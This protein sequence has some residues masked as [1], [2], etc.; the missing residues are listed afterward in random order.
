MESK[1]NAAASSRIDEEDIRLTT[2]FADIFTAILLVVGGSLLAGLAGPLGGIAI[3]GA[4]FL[5]GKPLVERRRFAASGNALAIGA[6]LGAAMIL[7]KS[8][9]IAVLIPAAV[10][11]YLFWRL[12]HVPLALALVWMAAAGFVAGSDLVDSADLSNQVAAAR[13]LLAG[14]LLF[15]AGMW[16]DSRDRLRL[17]RLT[18]V[19]F[20][21][22]LAA[23]P[24]LVHGFFSLSGAG[25][26]GDSD[27]VRPLFV[28]ITFAALA[29]VS[30]LIDRRPLL[31]SSFV[32]LVAATY[33]LMRDASAAANVGERELAAAMAPAVI[34]VLLLF[35]A[36]GWT[37][38]RRLLI[39]ALPD[40]I[41]GYLP[42]AVQHSAP[43]P[44]RAMALPAEEGEPVRL[45]LG[46][47][48]FFVALGAA[49]LFVGSIFVGVQVVASLSDGLFSNGLGSRSSAEAAA[50]FDR[51]VRLF[52]IPIALPATAMWL[53]AEYFVRIRRMAW[54]AIVS[55]C[56][57][58][59]TC[60]MLGC[61]AVAAW[62]Y[63]GN[64]AAIVAAAEQ[65]LPLPKAT[66][67]EAVLMVIAA[68]LIAALASLAFWWRHRVPISFALACA[69][70]LPLAFLSDLTAI[71][72]GHQSELDQLD[73]RGPMIA[74]GMIA[75]A[76]AMAW[77]RSD[78]DRATPRSDTGF[79]MHLLAGVLVIPV[80][81]S[82]L[83]GV[84]TGPVAALLGFFA[85][86]ALAVLIDRRAPIVVALPFLAKTLNLLVGGYAG[87]MVTLLALVGLLGLVLRWDQ[88]RGWLLVRMPIAAA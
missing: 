32:Y 18:D 24:L 58:A 62:W 43:A 53:V 86:T 74:C 34:G 60:L 52:W 38:L 46:F 71:L 67:G 57:F 3:I 87:P 5:L 9:D 81:F 84:P 2:G 65:N 22:H 72:T 41:T 66:E 31:A 80:G 8:L 83:L 78:P 61:Y 37:P 7:A 29:A 33:R 73:L 30:L 55:A 44:E 68:S 70:L 76:V 25:P 20:W 54:P 35:L 39:R 23:A 12:H 82:L 36:A 48:D 40:S 11:S 21:L 88:V 19:A 4:A 47:N 63:S 77:D 45:V 1:D 56:G 50:A 10:V 51:A 85:L 27:Q 26:F 13:A 42:P 6:A 75:F 59:I 64:R 14:L 79:W 28:L 69:T 49:S 17:T 16:Y 15:G